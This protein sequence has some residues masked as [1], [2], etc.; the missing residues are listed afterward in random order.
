MRYCMTIYPAIEAGNPSIRFLFE[1]AE[2][3]IVAKNTAAD[4]LLFMQDKARVMNDYSNCFDFE[5]KINGDWVEYEE[6]GE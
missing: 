3:M 4:L 6:F 2:Q 5:E 1:T